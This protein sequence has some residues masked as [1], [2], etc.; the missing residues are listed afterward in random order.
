MVWFT[1][2][3]SILGIFDAAY[4]TAKHYLDSSVYCPVGKSCETVLNSD[5]SVIFNIP[6]SLFGIFFYFTILILTL[7][8]LQTEKR[9]LIKIFFI[10]SLLGF[11]FSV[12]LFYLQ[13]LVIKAYCFYCILSAI[14]ILILFAAS[15]F[16]LFSQKNQLS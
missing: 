4:L 14:N 11:S 5:Y 12:W 8:Y 16:L 3:L 1:I 10:L 6:L 7:L 15:S 9:I 2:I 13:A